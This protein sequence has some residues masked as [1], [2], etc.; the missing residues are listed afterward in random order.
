MEDYKSFTVVVNYYE[1][2]YLKT[3]LP[4]EYP[5]SFA[6]YEHLAFFKIINDE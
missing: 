1:Y 3:A 2:I 6:N 4:P 5:A